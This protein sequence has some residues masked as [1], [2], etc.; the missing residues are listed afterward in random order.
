MQVDCYHSSNKFMCVS[1][2]MAHFN[3]PYHRDASLQGDLPGTDAAVP[4]RNTHDSYDVDDVSAQEQT[5]NMTGLDDGPD[6][7]SQGIKRALDNLLALDQLSTADSSTP[8]AA[9]TGSRRLLTIDCV[10]HGHVG[11]G[12]PCAAKAGSGASI[13]RRAATVWHTRTGDAQVLIIAAAVVA[14]MSCLAAACALLAQWPRQHVSCGLAGSQDLRQHHQPRSSVQA[15]GSHDD[16]PTALEKG[17]PSMQPT[18]ISCQSNG[19]SS[20]SS[21]TA[22]SAPS[23]GDR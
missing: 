14:V 7:I 3:T 19:S 10:Q 16:A 20:N 21:S 13:V 12:A 23:S 17:Q 1:I 18:T 11:Q 5:F 4:V 8:F 2:I 6:E 9:N 15:G 22:P